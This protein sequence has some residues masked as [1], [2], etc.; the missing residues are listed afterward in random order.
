MGKVIPF[1]VRLFKQI[2]AILVANAAGRAVVAVTTVTIESAVLVAWAVFL[3]AIN[4]GIVGMGLSSVFNS[5]P[6]TGVSATVM[7]LV[8]AAFPVH[9]AFGLACAYVQF[10]WSYVQAAFVMIRVVRVLLGG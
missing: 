2:L 6:L 7:T 5:N 9:F 8:C 3:A 10:K 1:I 4:T